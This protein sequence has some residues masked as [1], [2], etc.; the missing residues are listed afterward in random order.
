MGTF[1]KGKPKPWE[2]FK[3]PALLVN[4]YEIIKNRRLYLEIRERGGIHKFLEYDGIVFLDSGGFQ[5]MARK[6]TVNLD[7]LIRIYKVA[8][9]DYYFSLDFPSFSATSSKSDI[10][11][12]IENYRRLRKAIDD[13]IPIVHPP[14]ER[15]L[16]E[17]NAYLSYDPDYIAIGG[18]VPLIRTTKGISNGRKRAIDIIVMIRKQFS[19]KIHVMGLGA[20]T[21][22]PLL[23][24]LKCDSTDSASWRV[25]A[26]H[27]KIML[28][29]GGERYI[30]NKG[31]KFGVIR[32][33]EEERKI[34]ESLKCPIIEEF[35]WHSIEKSFE[36]RALLNAWITLHC[37]NGIKNLN[38]PFSKLLHYAERMIDSNYS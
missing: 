36:L 15:A 3:V 29:S 7:S 24:L 5:A 33:S 35:G 13:I 22:I 25:K 1:L 16:K 34:L 14:T 23:E 4:A 32:L 37:R 9:A 12:T 17:Y 11:R 20:P 6:I 38:G 8:K 27:G 21:V 10:R 26:A 31:A 2:Y 18:L 28:P 19:R 30:S